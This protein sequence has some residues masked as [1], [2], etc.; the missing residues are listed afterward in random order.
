MR[1]QLHHKCCIF[2]YLARTGAKTYTWCIAGPSASVDNSL[3]RHHIRLHLRPRQ[4][5]LH[6]L[7]IQTGKKRKLIKLCHEKQDLKNVMK[8]II[9]NTVITNLECSYY[10]HIAP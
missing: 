10:L 6:L 8:T 1:S 9:A 3:V 4:E 7:Q 5:H 2:C